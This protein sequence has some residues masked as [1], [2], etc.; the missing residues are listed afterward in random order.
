MHGG[1]SRCRSF[2]RMVAG[3]R[4]NGIAGQGGARKRPGCAWGL[5]RG[6]PGRGC[7]GGAAVAGAG[8]AGRGGATA[9]FGNGR[10]MHERCWRGVRGSRPTDHGSSS[11][12]TAVVPHRGERWGAQAGPAAQS[13]GNGADWES[14]APY[15]LNQGRTGKGR[16]P[17]IEDN[18]LGTWPRHNR[19]TG[20]NRGSVG[21]GEGSPAPSNR[22]G[23][24]S[25]AVWIWGKTRGCKEGC[26]RIYRGGVRQ[27]GCAHDARGV[28]RQGEAK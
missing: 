28:A 1:R 23:A 5:R 8:P 24:C 19:S 2:S 20:E 15:A 6:S 11:S 21:E 16:Q 12:S 9:A 25:C 27:G 22:R 13:R 7:A 26:V 3:R 4:R 18:L 17:W 10:Q 14:T